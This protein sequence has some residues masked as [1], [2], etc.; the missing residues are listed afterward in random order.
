MDAT[1][2]TEALNDSREEMG[3][4]TQIVQGVDYVM[5]GT[6]TMKIYL[7]ESVTDTSARIG[8][9]MSTTGWITTTSTTTERSNF[10]RTYST[11]EPTFGTYEKIK[12]NYINIEMLTGNTGDVI[13]DGEY[14]ITEV[15]NTTS[16]KWIEID[17]GTTA[18]ISG[19]L[20]MTFDLFGTG[21]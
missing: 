9:F 19:T 8:D 12:G 13:T 16:P 20:N 7:E 4:T 14:Q 6:S 15:S 21:Q 1:I 3:L 11:T 10:I 2:R 5:T 18:T 17:T